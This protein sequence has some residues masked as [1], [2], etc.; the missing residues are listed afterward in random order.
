MLEALLRDFSLRTFT[1][2]VISAVFAAATVQTL[3]A[4]AEAH[5]V[6]RVQAASKAQ[7]L[8]ARAQA[9]EEVAVC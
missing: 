7:E 6:A 8:A 2:I 4:H 9:L 1:P 3:E 5:A